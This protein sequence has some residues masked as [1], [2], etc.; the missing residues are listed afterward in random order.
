MRNNRAPNF[1]YRAF[2]LS[3]YDGDTVKVKID[4]GFSIFSVVVLRLKGIDT[5]ELRGGTPETKAAGRAA[6]DFTRS[7][8]VGQWCLVQTEQDKKGKYG[9]YIAEI[10]LNGI[11]FNNLL[12]AEG[13]AVEKHY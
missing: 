6:R 3:A 10:I 12:V 2:V 9:R 11:S 8:L 5:P 4:L 7:K 13:H 1:L